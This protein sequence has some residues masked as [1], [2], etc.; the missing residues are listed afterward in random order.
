MN[1]R[2]PP[3][4]SPGK[5]QRSRRAALVIAAITLTLIVVAMMSMM[6]TTRVDVIEPVLERK[7]IDQKVDDNTRSAA[8][9]PNH[10][11]SITEVLRSIL[12]FG[13]SLTAGAYYSASPSSS[14]NK[15][16]RLTFTTRDWPA[17]VAQ[18]LNAKLLTLMN[19][20][21]QGESNMATSHRMITVTHKGYPGKDS[22][23]LA[24]KLRA[25]LR[26]ANNDKHHSSGNESSEVTSAFSLVVILSGTNDIVGLKNNLTEAVDHIRGMHQDV[27]DI[28]CKS[29]HVTPFQ[30]AG[31]SLPTRRRPS[32]GSVALLTPPMN[33]STPLDWY[34]DPFTRAFCAGK[35]PHVHDILH[36][37]HRELNR[38]LVTSLSPHLPVFDWSGAEGIAA[39]HA[40]GVSPIEGF[41]GQGEVRQYWSDCLH[42]NRA[43]YDRFGLVLAEWI[44]E[45]ATK[46]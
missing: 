20:V 28:N 43:G 2:P 26:R 9:L 31:A 4:F 34:P 25:F 22:K 19:N 42:P 40:A 36:K 1:N 38:N 44:W 13:D 17:I 7:P 24:T 45:M 5:I 39:A 3:R 23:A 10:V 37:R 21:S 33:F 27:N 41:G 16:G 46:E 18:S 29:T 14:T 12:F 35:P 8:I 30:S 15:G 11:K 32:C 6:R